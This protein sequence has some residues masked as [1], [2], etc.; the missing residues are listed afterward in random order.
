MLNT[1]PGYAST[2]Q[3]ILDEIG[4]SDEPDL[5][6]DFESIVRKFQEYKADLNSKRN[7]NGGTLKTYGSRR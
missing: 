3:K 4:L 5:L 2:Q 7:K 6:V 1:Q